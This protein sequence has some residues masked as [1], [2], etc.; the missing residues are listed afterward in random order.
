MNY[1]TIP[2][3]VYIVNLITMY[4]IIEYL[5]PFLKYNE[6]KNFW[7]SLTTYSVNVKNNIIYIISVK[8]I[9]SIKTTKTIYYFKN[10]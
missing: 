3:I 7:H 6:K 4:T 9:V 2:H 1:L 10:W 5:N 8:F